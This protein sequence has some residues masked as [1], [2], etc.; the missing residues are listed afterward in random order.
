METVEAKFIVTSFLLDTSKEFFSE[1]PEDSEIKTYSKW[2]QKLFHEIH[3]YIMHHLDEPSKPL[4]ELAELFNSNEY[5]IKTGFKEIFG[6][7]P[8]QYHADQR[9]NQCKILIENTDL[10][11]T[12]ISIKMGFGSYPHFSKSFKEKTKVSPKHYKNI[13][14]NS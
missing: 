11:L 8:F 7:T 2:D 9:I 12:E 4:D 6:C 14:R 1:L 3:I 5:K 10:S 13:I